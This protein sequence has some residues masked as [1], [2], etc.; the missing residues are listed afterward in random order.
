MQDKVQNFWQVDKSVVPVQDGSITY[1]YNLKCC[2]DISF[3]WTDRLCSE[4][5]LHEINEARDR[6]SSVHTCTCTVQYNSLT[7]ARSSSQSATYCITYF[8]LT[9]KSHVL[10][11]YCVKC[12]CVF[13]LVWQWFTYHDAQHY[14]HTK[15]NWI[16]INENHFDIYLS[17]FYI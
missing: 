9:H 14:E 16:Y 13:W 8:S 1:V 4:V 6:L 11:P 3:P 2:K 10:Q 17:F 7:R 12:V 15:Y 5:R